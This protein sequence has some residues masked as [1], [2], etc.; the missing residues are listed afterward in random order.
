LIDP[1]VLALLPLGAMASGF[2]GARV[3][4]SPAHRAC[5]RLVGPAF[6][7][8]Q[9]PDRSYLPFTYLRSAPPL[10]LEPAGIAFKGAVTWCAP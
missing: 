10:R 6:V 9:A 1:A 8:L 5:G 4:P 2:R 3:G 7:S